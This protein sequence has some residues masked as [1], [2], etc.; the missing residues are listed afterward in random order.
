MFRPL[1]KFRYIKNVVAIEKHPESRPILAELAPAPRYLPCVLGQAKSTG[2]SGARAALIYKSRHI[3]Y[4][5]DGLSILQSALP[6][7]TFILVIS[8]SM[9]TRTQHQKTSDQ[10]FSIA[11]IT[12]HSETP[13]NISTRFDIAN[14]DAERVR[15]ILITCGRKVAP[16]ITPYRK[17]TCSVHWVVIRTF[18]KDGTKICRIP[19]RKITPPTY[20]LKSFLEI[21]NR[22]MVFDNRLMPLKNIIDTT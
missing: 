4:E 7:T 10:F 17:P 11:N 9:P 19:N 3:S 5:Y 12:V 1:H 14:E 15:W 8:M 6:R 22:I 13:P 21:K 18:R 20:S 16:A 2:F